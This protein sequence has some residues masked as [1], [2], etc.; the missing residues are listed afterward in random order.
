MVYDFFFFSLV[1]LEWTRLPNTRPDCIFAAKHIRR[2]FTGN[3]KASVVSYPPFPG[4]EADYLRSQ[5]ARL[6]SATTLGPANFYQIAEEDEV[7]EDDEENAANS[8]YPSSLLS[9]PIDYGS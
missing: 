2:A 9:C 8:I 6:V 1:G 7:D 5:I 4:N 3:L